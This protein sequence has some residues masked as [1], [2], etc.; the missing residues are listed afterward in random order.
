[1]TGQAGATFSEEPVRGPLFKNQR[2]MGNRGE[3]KLE[4]HLARVTIK[5]GAS[6]YP[7]RPAIFTQPA[8]SGADYSSSQTIDGQK[9]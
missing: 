5:V 9:N 1:M 2:K 8:M 7:G 6:E 4:G 3:G